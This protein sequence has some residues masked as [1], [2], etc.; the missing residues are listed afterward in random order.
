M[1]QQVNQSEWLWKLSDQASSRVESQLLGKTVVRCDYYGDLGPRG[2][3]LHQSQH[4][5]A[6]TPEQFS[7]QDHDVGDTV[8]QASE[9]LDP[10]GGSLHFVPTAR[11]VA[12]GNFEEPESLSAI[13]TCI[14]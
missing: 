3:L 5:S 1:T 12:T 11:Y 2:I 9:T 8:T 13:S 14:L 6:A 7:I 4:S 10:I